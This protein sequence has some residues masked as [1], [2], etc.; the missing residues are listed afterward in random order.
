MQTATTQSVRQMYDRLKDEDGSV[1]GWQ[2]LSTDTQSRSGDTGSRYCKQINCRRTM[3]VKNYNKRFHVCV[4]VQLKCRCMCVCFVCSYDVPAS[5]L[6][7]C[8]SACLRVCVCV[9]TASRCVLSHMQKDMHVFLWAFLEHELLYF[10]S[11]SVNEPCAY[12]FMSV[13]VYKSVHVCRVC[14]V[15]VFLFVRVSE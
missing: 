12:V 2:L 15:S 8:V 5:A 10:V 9:C 11:V 4:R 13:R 14:R 6:V 1:D 3:T 7:C